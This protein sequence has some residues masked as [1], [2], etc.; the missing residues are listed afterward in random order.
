MGAR[1]KISRGG[2]ADIFVSQIQVAIMQCIW[3]FTKRFFLVYNYTIKKM[4]HVAATA[5]KALRWQ[6]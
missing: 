3:T 5:R 4:P 2:N 1:K 6:K